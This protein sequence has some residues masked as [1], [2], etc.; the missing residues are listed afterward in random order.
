MA[1]KIIIIIL[2]LAL[3]GAGAYGTYH[4]YALNEQAQLDKSLILSQTAQLQSRLDSIGPITTVYTVNK[5]VSCGEVIKAEDLTTMT[6]PESSVSECVVKD[7]TQILGSYWRVGMSPGT[8]VT[9][10]V[11]MGD[12]L[13]ETVYELDMSFDYL[14]LGLKVGDYIDVRIVLPFGETYYVMT[15][16]RVEQMVLRTNTIKVYA[17]ESETLLYASARK[18]YAVYGDSG[19]SII[20]TKYVEPGIQDKTIAFYPVRVDVANSVVDNPNILD[21]NV[22]I[23]AALREKIDLFLAPTL[24]LDMGD[25]V[26]ELNDTAQDINTSVE[27]YT[28][29]PNSTQGSVVDTNPTGTTGGNASG[30]NNAIGNLNSTLEEFGS[31]ISSGDKNTADGKGESSGENAIE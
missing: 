30:L 7:Y 27:S 25:I 11:V 17:T 23:N 31:A 28:E 21:Q 8:I 4:F 2:F 29:D 15:H 1:K 20:I 3:A 10:D 22:L 26:G 14:P 6:F 24:D 16:K 13:T 19:L 18:D 12:K 5:S 9:N